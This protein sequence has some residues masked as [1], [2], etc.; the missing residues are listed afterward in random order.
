MRFL[1]EAGLRKAAASVT[2]VDEVT[3]VTYAH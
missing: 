1:R 2:T 3:R